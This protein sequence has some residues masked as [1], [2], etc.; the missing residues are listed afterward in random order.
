MTKKATK[1]KKVRATTCRSF[2]VL[3]YLESDS[4]NYLEVLDNL[5]NYFPK[6]SYIIHDK[7]VYLDGDNKGE[8]KKHIFIS[9][10]KK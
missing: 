6:Y 1:Q 8:L 4:Y 7:D 9:M 5:I 2:E 10:G 3:I